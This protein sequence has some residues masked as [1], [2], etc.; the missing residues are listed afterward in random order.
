[1]TDIVTSLWF[2]GDAEEAVGFYTSL[3]PNSSIDHVLRA[4]ADGPETTTGDVIQVSFTLCGRRFN[5]INGGRGFPFTEAISLALTADTQAEAD[6]YWDTLTEGGEESQ[7]GWLKDRFGL[8]W[9][10]VPAPAIELLSSADP[11][12]ARRATEAMFTMRRI[13]SE[14]M[15]RAAFADN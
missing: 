4:A 15:R 14:E 9:Q 3:I 6:A 13:D 1:M 7:C 8:S 5:A 11:Q 12:V 10:I 2:D